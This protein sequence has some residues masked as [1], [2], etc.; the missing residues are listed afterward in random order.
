M[1]LGVARCIESEED[2]ILLLKTFCI[3]MTLTG[4]ET[5]MMSFAA[6]RAPFTEYL[7]SNQYLN[8]ADIDSPK[9]Q[10]ALSIRGT[11]L[12]GV[13]NMTGAFLNMMLPLAVVLYRCSSRAA[14]YRIIAIAAVAVSIF[15]TMTTYSRSA[16]LGFALLA[17]AVIF[18]GTFRGKW[19]IIV[20]AIAVAMSVAWIGVD[21]D[22][23]NFDRLERR[24]NAAIYNPYANPEESERI[25]SYLDA[26]QFIAKN[27]TLLFVGEGVNTG[28]F[29][30][31]SAKR[32]D[33]SV[34]GR[35]LF[36]YGLIASLC[37]C[38]LM[39]WA[40]MTA[41]KN[42]RLVGKRSSLFSMFAQ[43]MFAS[44]LA[45]LPWFM[46][47][48]PIISNPRASSFYFAMVGIVFAVNRIAMSRAIRRRAGN[49]TGQLGSTRPKP[50]QSEMV[51]TNLDHGGK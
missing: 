20:T 16:Y 25:D 9:F 27:P 36:A 33:H 30:P 22:Y 40:L 5:S 39:F 50:H 6:T 43:A 10:S 42:I 45:V 7:F 46:F 18:M 13:S 51:E 38:F 12:V 8:S 2:I 21:S 24:M 28:A 37:Y 11:S 23:F 35:A 47:T 1:C 19:L 14:I 41:F 49:Q 29:I 26:G 32:P 44:M 34:F 3:G 48:H 31:W 4:L 15:A 17:L